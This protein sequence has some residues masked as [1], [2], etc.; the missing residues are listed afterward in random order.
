MKNTNFSRFLFAQLHLDSVIGNRSPKAIRATLIKL[1]SRFDVYDH[2]YRDVM[3]RIE[4]QLADQKELAKQV[5]SGITCAKRPLAT[6]E[7]EH[8][9]AVEPKLESLDKDNLLEIKDKV[10]VCAGLITVIIRVTL[11]A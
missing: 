6:S 4:G 10:F 9:L 1:P 8:A 2:A 5:L 7:I 11:S 3:T